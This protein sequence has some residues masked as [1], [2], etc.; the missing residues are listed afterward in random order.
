MADGKLCR[1]CYD[2]SWRRGDGP[3]CICF[4]CREP[5]ESEP[6]ITVAE[7]HAQPRGESRVYP[8]AYGWRAGR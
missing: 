2:Q 8:A 6:P 3:R 5:Y 4:G 7:Q 1:V